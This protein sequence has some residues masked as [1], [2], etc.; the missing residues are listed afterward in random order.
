MLWG[1]KA[2]HWR[3]DKNFQDISKLGR[4]IIGVP[5]LHNRVEEG[6]LARSI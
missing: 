6:N 3:K 1:D 5:Y 4:Q 2:E